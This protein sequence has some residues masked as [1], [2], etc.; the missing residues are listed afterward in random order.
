MKNLRIAS[1]LLKIA[2]ELV[3][4]DSGDYIYDPDHKKHPGG[5]YH[6][7]EKG[8]SKLEEKKDKGKTTD[9]SAPKVKMT[10]KQKELDKEAE[11]DDWYTRC[12]VAE[13]SNA[14]PSTLEKLSKDKS[15]Y[16]RM[17]VAKNPNCPLETLIK[18]SEDSELRVQYG[19]AENPKC[20]SEILDKMSDNAILVRDEIAKNPNTSIKTLNKLSKD[21]Y[22][23]LTRRNVA[24]NPNTHPSTLNRLSND[25]YQEVRKAVAGNPNTHPKTL[26]KLSNDKDKDVRGSVAEN[27]NTS[28]KTLE[29]MSKV[30][31]DSEHGPSYLAFVHLE[32]RKEKRKNEKIKQNWQKHGFDITK[33]S[34]KMREKVKDWDAEDI[35][36]FIGW[37]KEHKG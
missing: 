32:E 33:L 34:P 17:N 30:K 12:L 8:W 10:N 25:K 16:I 27:P 23:S 22:D 26:N 2:E 21:K 14:H 36:K 13:S 15:D 18:L 1:K 4:A 20:P 11:S 31:D 3:Y 5:G 24:K 28:D 37:L 19:V 7:T 35:A 9:K 29:K 6:K